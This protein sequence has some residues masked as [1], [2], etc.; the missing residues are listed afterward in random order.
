MIALISSRADFTSLSIIF[1]VF[2]CRNLALIMKIRCVYFCDN[3]ELSKNS[4]FDIFYDF[5]SVI[6][7]FLIL[8][9]LYKYFN[10]ILLH[11]GSCMTFRC[12]FL[13]AEFYLFLLRIMADFKLYSEIVENLP[14]WKRN[15]AKLRKIFPIS[16]PT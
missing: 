2:C 7:S 3:F 13:F 11:H 1:V 16:Q 9:S 5:Q 10:I 15:R 14:I 4:V 12:F 6:F 8:S